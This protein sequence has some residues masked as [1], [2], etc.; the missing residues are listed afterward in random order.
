MMVHRAMEAAAALAKEGVE[1]EVVDLRTLS[2]IDWD[3]VI[4]S[5]RRPATWSAS[6]RPTRAARSPPTSPP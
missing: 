4:D 5:A 1:G 2:P 3:T 6:T